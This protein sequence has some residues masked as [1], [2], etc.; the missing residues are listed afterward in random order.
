MEYGTSRA[1]A[2]QVPLYRT[3]DVDALPGAHPEVDREELRRVEKARRSPLAALRPKTA[4]V[5]V[6]VSV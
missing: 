3:A 1:E 4:S 6:S 5:S 2:V